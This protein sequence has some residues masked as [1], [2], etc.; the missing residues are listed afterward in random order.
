MRAAT[1]ELLLPD[2]QARPAFDH[3]T[4]SLSENGRYPGTPFFPLDDHRIFPT[5]M[6]ENGYFY[7]GHPPFE[8]D[9]TDDKTIS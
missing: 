6:I 4:R 1:E 2:P 9:Q 5:K 7:E 3:W 8:N